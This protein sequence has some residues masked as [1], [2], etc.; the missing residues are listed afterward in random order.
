M[1]YEGGWAPCASQKPRAIPLAPTEGK[2]KQQWYREAA[3]RYFT[4][5]EI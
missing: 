3:W 2:I 1:C 4:S 5:D